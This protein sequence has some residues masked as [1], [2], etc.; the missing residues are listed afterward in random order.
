MS[1]AD[2]LNSDKP[3]LKDDVRISSFPV[4]E[5]ILG[6][7]LENIVTLLCSTGV[8][9]SRVYEEIMAMV[10]KSLIKIALQRSNNVKSCAAD[11]LGINR[12][13]LHKKMRKFGI[14]LQKD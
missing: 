9:K 8:E 11:L 1:A 12:N 2:V 7:K 6:E 10:E 3:I 4:I 5:D 13:T 14:S